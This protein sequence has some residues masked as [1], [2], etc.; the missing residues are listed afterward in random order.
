M[1]LSF[2]NYFED[3][4]NFAGSA[5]YRERKANLGEI[6]LQGYYQWKAETK[7]QFWKLRI[8]LPAKYLQK[9][10]FA[11]QED[12]NDQIQQFF[13]GNWE[14]QIYKMYL[15][16]GMFYAKSFLYQMSQMMRIML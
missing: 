3:A 10:L 15:V 6:F 2:Y 11:H 9:F 4:L 14:K 16:F 1:V 12:L 13:E 7:F 8:C 5:N